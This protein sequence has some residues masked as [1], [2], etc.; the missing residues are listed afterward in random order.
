MGQY[1]SP[2]LAM[3]NN[4][5]SLTDP[6]GGWGVD[7]DDDFDTRN[8]HG[9]YFNTPND[10]PFAVLDNFENKNNAQANYNYALHELWKKEAD[11]QY[12]ID[13][14][15]WD[16]PGVEITAEGKQ[17]Y[18]VHGLV[19][20]IL[21]Y[22]DA[23]HINHNR[24]KVGIPDKYA[25]V[26]GY[27]AYQSFPFEIPG[28]SKWDRIFRRM[29]A[30]HSEEMLDFGGGGY[31]MFGGYGTVVN[32]A[33]KTGTAANLTAGE[34]L[35]IENAATRINESITVIGSRAIPGRVS[36]GVNTLT[37]NMADWDYVIEGISSGKWDKIKNSLPGAH[38]VL[39]NTPRNIDVFKGALNK[40][41]PHITINPRP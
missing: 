37:G 39:D 27:R 30:N 15:E 40:K 14:P 18:D 24:G 9:A 19:Q 28:E 35:R 20:S 21:D 29:A 34:I 1:H 25:G 8:P 41:L 11:E 3:G 10:D 2:Y 13:H 38:S 22:N 16:L 23:I 33:S 6:S 32:S 7:F 36:N 12:R 31:N 5:V 4:P 26:E 17:S